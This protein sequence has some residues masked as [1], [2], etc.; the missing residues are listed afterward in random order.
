MCSFPWSI[1]PLPQMWYI[2]INSMHFAIFFLTI[3][4]YLNNISFCFSHFHTISDSA[5]SLL[6][7]AICEIHSGWWFIPGGPSGQESICQSTRCKRHR[8]DPWVGKIHW[9]RKWQPTPIFLPGEFHQQRSLVGYSPW[10]AKSQTR[11]RD[12]GH[13]GWYMEFLFIHLVFSLFRFFKKNKKVC[14]ISAFSPFPDLRDKDRSGFG[15]YNTLSYLFQ[16]IYPWA[17]TEV[18]VKVLLA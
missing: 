1:P 18:K 14:P 5:H 13:P 16:S 4:V 10:A 3:F 17:H 12:W 2:F 11:L 9:K 8:F 15:I 7:S 6:L